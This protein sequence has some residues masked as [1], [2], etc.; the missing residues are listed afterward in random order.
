M[1]ENENLSIMQCVSVRI[2]N[3]FAYSELS[4][5]MMNVS[6]STNSTSLLGTAPDVAKAI[7]PIHEYRL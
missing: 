7:S 5:W 2:V 4:V 6:S 3:V 1:S